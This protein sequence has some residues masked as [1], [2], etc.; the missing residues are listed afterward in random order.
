MF[1]THPLSKGDQSLLPPWAGCEYSPLLTAS[2]IWPHIQRFYY[3]SS[4]QKIFFDRIAA[5]NRQANGHQPKMALHFWSFWSLAPKIHSKFKCWQVRCMFFDYPVKNLNISA[6]SEQLEQFVSLKK[7]AFLKESNIYFWF[8]C[9]IL[10]Y[11]VKD[12]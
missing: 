3:N 9:R 8:F 2:R 10:L 11:E 1:H 5:L 6:K 4:S 12:S 7:F